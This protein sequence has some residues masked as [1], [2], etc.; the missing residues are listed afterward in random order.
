MLIGLAFV[1]PGPSCVSAS[2]LD[3]ITFTTPVS[4]CRPTRSRTMNLF[5]LLVVVGGT[6]ACAG[7]RRAHR[8]PRTAGAGTAG[9]LGGWPDLLLGVLI[10]VPARAGVRHPHREPAPGPRADSRCRRPR[11]SGTAMVVPWSEVAR[12]ARLLDAVPAP[13]TRSETPGDRRRQLAQP[14]AAV[15]R[16]P[17]PSPPVIPSRRSTPT[18]PSPCCVTTSRT[19]RPAPSSSDRRPAAREVRCPRDRARGRRADRRVDVLVVCG[20]RAGADHAAGAS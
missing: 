8:G 4:C 10:L 14:G 7:S 15:G 18:P 6:L 2:D 9:R 17:C 1:G 5:A 13:R 16:T 12:D 11:T 20:P 19:R 3:P